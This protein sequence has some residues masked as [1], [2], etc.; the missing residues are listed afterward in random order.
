M[1]AT[2]R[3]VNSSHRIDVT[4]KDQNSRRVLLASVYLTHWYSGDV[5]YNARL[6]I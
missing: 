6:N 1:Q 4:R 3:D 5:F 2:N